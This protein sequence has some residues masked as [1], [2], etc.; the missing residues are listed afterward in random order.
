MEPATLGKEA[1]DEV[2]KI[3]KAC[4]SAI[5][6][7]YQRARSGQNID[8]DKFKRTNERLHSAVE[9]YINHLLAKDEDIEE[10]LKSLEEYGD[11]AAFVCSKYDQSAPAPTAT[12]TSTT[13]AKQLELKLP[14][15]NAEEPASWIT[16]QSM[17]NLYDKANDPEVAKKVELIKVLPP[18]L[19]SDI[20]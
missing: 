14:K 4:R 6:L 7:A 13:K 17:L 19:A 18:N 20:A 11:K 16:V 5:T 3:R 1:L 12:T 8:F 2:V 10:E 15:V 9:K